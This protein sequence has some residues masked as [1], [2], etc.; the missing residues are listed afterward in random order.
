[1]TE[2]WGELND[3]LLEDETVEGIVFGDWGGWV[4]KET[5][6]L[7]PLSQRY[8][9]LSLEEAEPM[10]FGWSFYGGFGSPDCFP[11]VVWTDKRVISVVEYDGATGLSSF[12]RN[13][14]NHEPFFGS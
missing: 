1:M 3:Y 5:E 7:V 13:P 6:A 8:K 14:I 9:V 11:S 4:T 2:A 10:M 12:P